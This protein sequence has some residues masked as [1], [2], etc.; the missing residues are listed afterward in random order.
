MTGDKKMGTI[1]PIGGGI[2]VAAKQWDWLE[3]DKAY[4][5]ESF[6]SAMRAVY[7]YLYIQGAWLVIKMNRVK[8]HLRVWLASLGVFLS[9][10]ALNMQAAVKAAVHNRN[11]EY[12]EEFR[13]LNHRYQKSRTRAI[14]R[15]GEGA[16]SRLL[17]TA[18]ALRGSSVIVGRVLATLAN[19]VA[20]VIAVA[21]LMYTVN[22]FSHV[23]YGLKVSLNGKTL[24]YISNENVYQKAEKEMQSR[25]YYEEGAKALYT[26]PSFTLTVVSNKSFIDDKQL[27]DEII[28]ASGSEISEA[29]GLYIDG[30]FYGA[31]NNP[32]EVTKALDSVKKKYGSGIKGE[33][34]SFAEDIRLQEGYYLSTSIKPIKSLTSQLTRETEGRRTYEVEEGDTPSGIAAKFGISTE[35]LV[36]LNPDILDSLFIG[37]EILL[38]NSKPFLTVIASATEITEKEIG[39]ETEKVEDSSKYSTYASIAQTGENGIAKVT[40]KVI[41]ENGVQVDRKEISTEVIKEPVN[42]RIIVGTKASVP[43]PAPAKTTS[44]SSGSS[45]TIKVNPSGRFGWPLS[46]GG[47]ITCHFWGYY[48][49]TGTDIQTF[50]GDSVLAADS[51]VVVYTGFQRYG[52]G[53]HVIIDHQNG[54]QT[55]YAHCSSIAV[56][57]GQSVQK[58]QVI[59]Y[60]GATGR[61]TGT[62]LHFEI[63]VGGRAVNAYP[64]LTS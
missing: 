64:Y 50:Y 45:T 54:F 14:E 20:P 61:V 9:V 30:K 47:R 40:A 21:I 11:A 32:A 58:G 49:H 51:G 48:G 25:I 35:E 16:L 55:L 26:T 46:G 33:T 27:C 38:K 31:T 8:R 59:A 63:R 42:Q 1:E 7:A 10:R 22:F 19:C 6:E 43:A 3:A 4:K 29:T 37:D 60:E 2:G 34:V 44:P 13:R 57:V 18:Y 23:S 15:Y 62:H 28:L 12:L 5:D 41:Y 52:Y 17:T 56:S 36:N 53:Y 24:G 39:Y